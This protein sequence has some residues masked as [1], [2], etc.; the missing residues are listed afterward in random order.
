MLF[1]TWTRLRLNRIFGFRVSW[2]N[3]FYMHE[4]IGFC[5]KQ[6]FITRKQKIRVTQRLDE[7]SINIYIK[8]KPLRTVNLTINET[9]KCLSPLPIIVEK[10]L[11]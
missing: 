8:I 10:S 3:Q 7:I 9:L 6:V 2:S 4:V 1:P 11:W 5:L